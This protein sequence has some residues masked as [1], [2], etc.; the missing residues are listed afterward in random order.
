MVQAGSDPVR[1]GETAKPRCHVE[2]VCVCVQEGSQAVGESA[3]PRKE[4]K[5]ESWGGGAA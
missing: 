5:R 1:G 3:H 4:I 2:L